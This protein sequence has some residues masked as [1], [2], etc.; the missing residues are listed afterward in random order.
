[1]PSGWPGLESSEAPVRYAG[2]SEDS[3]PGHPYRTF[4]SWLSINVPDAQFCSALS[5]AF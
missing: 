5:I 3:S 4:L 2:A 1:M